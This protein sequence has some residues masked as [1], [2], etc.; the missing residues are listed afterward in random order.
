MM[1]EERKKPQAFSKQLQA[2][3]LAPSSNQNPTNLRER[4]R[5]KREK[6]RRGMRGERVK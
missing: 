6:K 2:Q 5:R 1:E 4:G 3:T